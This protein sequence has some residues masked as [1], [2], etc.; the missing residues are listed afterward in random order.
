MKKKDLELLI[1]AGDV[2]TITITREFST[3]NA[4][5]DGKP[6]GAFLPW[7]MWIQGG[8]GVERA[9]SCIE[10]ARNERRGWIRLQSAYDFARD[11]GWKG[12]IQLEDRLLPVKSKK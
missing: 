9:G 6:V 2:E 7:E 5:P 8:E 1:S 10:T 3:S 12:M 4:A 11:A